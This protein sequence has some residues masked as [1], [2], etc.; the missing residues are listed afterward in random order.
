[1]DQCFWI[2][3][4]KS[5]ISVGKLLFLPKDSGKFYFL[6]TNEMAIMNKLISIAGILL[7]FIA[8]SPAYRTVNYVSDNHSIN[9]Q[10]DSVSD[11]AFI[12]ILSPYKAKV[13][14]EMSEVISYS[15][16]S[17]VSYRPESPLS[18]FISDLILDHGKK[19]AAKNQFSAAI[20]FSLINHGGLRTSLPKGA[21]RRGDIFELM[22]FENELVLLKFSGKQVLELADYLASR[23]GEGVSGMSFGIKA[24]KA[25]DVTVDDKSVVVDS[26]Y[27]MITNDYLANG[28]DGMIVL[29]TAGK[30]IN[31]GEKIRDVII[32]YMKEL[33]LAGKRVT[34]KTDGRVYHVE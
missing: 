32:N 22:P 1:L 25:V 2:I 16:T 18:N 27:W 31:T 23:G 13:T 6:L 20:N 12:E 33:K 15:D 10:T 28:G 8:C 24:N 30:R 21:I 14:T 34:A 19:Y 11:P 3:F 5:G 4:K 29:T 7:I 9:L 17:L 26:V